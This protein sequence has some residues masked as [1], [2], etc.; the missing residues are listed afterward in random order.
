MLLIDEP[1]SIKINN[2]SY[3]FLFN[4]DKT[5]TIAEES[6][7]MIKQIIS[8]KKSVLSIETENI[9]IGN[10]T[11]IEFDS[12]FEFDNSTFRQFNNNEINVLFS[13]VNNSQLNS[14]DY[15]II[16]IKM[17][18]GKISDLIHQ[19]LRDKKILEKI[20]NKNFLYVGFINSK[21]LDGDISSL[22][23]DLNFLYLD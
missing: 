20:Y 9:E 16:E 17:N 22:I 15:I 19:L 3:V 8:N 4:K 18:K 11:E 5:V 23:G 13:N 2:K 10:L 12:S 14:F 21:N 7:K 6:R 1:K